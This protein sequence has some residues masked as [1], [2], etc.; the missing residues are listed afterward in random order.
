M[1]IL[2]TSRWWSH[3]VDEQTVELLVILVVMTLM[4]HYDENPVGHFN[5]AYA[6]SPLRCE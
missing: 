1:T 5:E 3:F 4:C 6:L 2:H